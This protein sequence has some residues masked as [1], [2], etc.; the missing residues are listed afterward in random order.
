L[1]NSSLYCPL[2]ERWIPIL[3]TVILKEDKVHYKEHFKY[4][5]QW[6]DD[7]C[8][9]E[10]KNCDDFYAQVIDFSMAEK[11][12]FIDAFIEHKLEKNKLSSY[13]KVLLDSHKTV[14]EK[15]ALAFLKG[16]QE[17]Y[18]QSITRIARNS[19]IVKHED[20]TKFR[21]MTLKLLKIN[22]EDFFE[23]VGEI[24]ENWPNSTTW[25]E[26]W[27]YTDAGKILFPALSTMDEGLYKKLPGSTNAQESMHSQYYMCGATNQSIITG[28]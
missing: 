8:E 15:E 23:Q 17:H 26:W 19:A 25:L 3:I 27:V 6:I 2:L 28:I 1:N 12:G 7:H 22:F 16:C 11:R 4:L 24:Q 21:S 14:L 9:S 13:S 10:T 5:F 18:K 20:S